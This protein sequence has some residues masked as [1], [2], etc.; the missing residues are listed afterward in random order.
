M[1]KLTTS[2]AHYVRPLPVLAL[3]A[4]LLRLRARRAEQLRLPIEEKR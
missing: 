2:T 1:T 3:I 4:A